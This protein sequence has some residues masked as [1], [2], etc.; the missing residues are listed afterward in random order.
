[1]IYVTRVRHISIIKHLSI[2]NLPCGKQA[3]I[4]HV[5]S[6]FSQFFFFYVAKQSSY[7]LV[8]SFLRYL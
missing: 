3:Y 8:N 2:I 5:Y 1:M 6:F 4:K 7:N